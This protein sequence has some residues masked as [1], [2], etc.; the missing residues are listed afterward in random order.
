MLNALENQTGEVL[1]IC[2]SHPCDHMWAEFRSLQPSAE[3]FSPG[4]LVFSI[5]KIDSQVIASGCRSMLR[6]SIMDH[7]VA[8]GHHLF[9]LSAR[10]HWAASF[11]IQSIRMQTRVSFFSFL[12][13]LFFP[14]N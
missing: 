5:I 14:C 10:F 13:S 11:V 4:T 6:G 3:F 7:M 1:I 8:T 12:L 2:A 9:I